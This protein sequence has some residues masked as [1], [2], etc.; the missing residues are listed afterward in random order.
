MF[1]I[2]SERFNIVLARCV[3]T[4]RAVNLKVKV[5]KI[6]ELPENSPGIFMESVTFDENSVPIEVLCSYYRGD[7]Y[8]FEIE[9]GRYRIRENNMEAFSQ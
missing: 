9:L 1:K 8:I 6:L 2:I 7:K 4:I 5:A 3:Q